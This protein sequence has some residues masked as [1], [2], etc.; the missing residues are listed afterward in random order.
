MKLQY[1]LKSDDGIWVFIPHSN[2]EDV[3][4]A[5]LKKVFDW[6]FGGEK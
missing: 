4:T 1:I 5:F 2:K 3:V 6:I